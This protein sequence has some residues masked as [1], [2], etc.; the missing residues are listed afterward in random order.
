[1][2]QQTIQDIFAITEAGAHAADVLSRTRDRIRA[3][4]VFEGGEIVGRTGRGL[5]RFVLAEGLGETGTKALGALDDFGTLRFDTRESLRERGLLSGPD[6]SSLLILRLD[7]PNVMEAALVLGHSRAWSFAAAPLFQIRTLAS[8]ALR[9]L[10]AD[11]RE[12]Q[13]RQETTDL[14]GEVA[15]LRTQV[16]SLQNEVANLRTQ[17]PPKG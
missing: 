12:D 1:M 11:D 9:L 15:R 13:T 6:H 4:E 3:C 7:A 17:P 14:R 2:F 10:T 5:F 8:I 16:S